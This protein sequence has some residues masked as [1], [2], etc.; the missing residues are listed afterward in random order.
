MKK[1]GLVYRKLRRM[2]CWVDRQQKQL[3]LM[4]EEVKLLKLVMEREDKPKS[5][6]VLHQLDI[7]DVIGGENGKKDRPVA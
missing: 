3:H 2:E 5:K 7:W 4:R 6:A 1:E